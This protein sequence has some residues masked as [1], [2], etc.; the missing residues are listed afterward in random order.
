MSKLTP[1]DVANWSPELVAGIPTAYFWAFIRAVPT[2]RALGAPGAVG[3]DTANV[4]GVFRASL[5]AV[6]GE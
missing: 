6:K 1:V 5:Q 3:I 4:E 2:R